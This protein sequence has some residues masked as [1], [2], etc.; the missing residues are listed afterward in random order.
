MA[1]ASSVLKIVA[2]YI[3]IDSDLN[4][5]S[6]TKV[7]EK[8]T[9]QNITQVSI[10]D[11]PE[12]NFDGSSTGQSETKNSDLILNPIYF[13]KNTL[14]EKSDKLIDCYYYIV[15]CEVVGDKSNN[16]KALVDVFEKTIHEEPWFGIE[17]EYI[18]CDVHG[19]L[20]N[21]NMI[22]KNHIDYTQNQHY[23]SSGS[24]RAFGRKIVMEHLHKCLEAGIKICGINSEV[25]P[26]QW[27]FQIGPL[28][29]LEVSNQLWVARYMLI[30]ISEKYDVS[31][32]FH[33]KPFSYY[34]GSGA[35][36]NFST[37]TMREDGGLNKIYEA[38]EKLSNN[39]SKH[40]EVYGLYNE[41]RLIGT[42]ETANINTFSYGN[43]D[44]SS[45]VRIP[46]NV[47]KDKKGYLEDRRP[48]ANIDPYLVT[49]RLLKTIILNQYE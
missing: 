45:S 2:E 13:I 36:T 41:K 25:T 42:H 19:N 23:C 14:I 46:V 27:E 10:S 12:W 9:T 15:L 21:Q 8:D 4:I 44:R 34:N 38:I 32:T 30:Q 49:A 5:R 29:A 1:C 26:S 33:P 40:I 31:I 48:A 35:H 16:Y 18:M 37:K 28:N 3:W 24:G 39:H 11:F 20:Y 7:I 47:M 43:C 22:N 6:K 17:Q